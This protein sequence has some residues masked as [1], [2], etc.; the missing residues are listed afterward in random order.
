MD[1]TFKTNQM[2]MLR[3][4]WEKLEGCPQCVYRATQHK[5]SLGT[6]GLCLMLQVNLSGPFLVEME[7]DF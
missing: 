6:L 1:N 3:N 5:A 4:G 2:L 7:L